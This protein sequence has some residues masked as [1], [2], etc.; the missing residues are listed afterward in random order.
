MMRKWHLNYFGS[1]P[2]LCEG[3]T[4]YP[5]SMAKGITFGKDNW[6][7]LFFFLSLP[8]LNVERGG[9]SNTHVSVYLVF[10][11]FAICIFVFEFWERGAASFSKKHISVLDRITSNTHCAAVFVYPYIHN[12]VF[13]FLY[14][15]L[16]IS[17]F[18]IFICVF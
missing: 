16:R 17:I 15:Y 11:V 18:V 9:A 14:F 6:D 1:C 7:F 4:K 5:R 8:Y 12:F 13:V 2:K 10:F 3:I